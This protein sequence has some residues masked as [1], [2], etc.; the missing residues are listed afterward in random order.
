[1]LWNSQSIQL[2]IASLALCAIRAAGAQETC[3]LQPDQHLQFVDVFDGAPEELATLIPDRDGKRSGYWLLAY[4]Y[5]SGRFVTVRCK[6][7]KGK[8]LDVKLGEPIK[9]CSYSINSKKTL[10]VLCR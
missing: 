3:P 5:E 6:Y 4:V 1:M 9:Q 2:V 7:T 10:K 8:I